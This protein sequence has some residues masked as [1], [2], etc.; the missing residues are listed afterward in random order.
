MDTSSA[1]VNLDKF[2]E[3]YTELASTKNVENRRKPQ[4]AGNK[5]K[6]TARTAS[7]TSRSRKA[8]DRAERLQRIQLEKARKAQLKVSI[9]T[10]S[11]WASWPAA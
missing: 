4:P 10:R 7:A 9:P 11:P 6:F 8:R 3:K 2:N 5:Q 1:D